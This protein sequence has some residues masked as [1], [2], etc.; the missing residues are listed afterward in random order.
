MSDSDNAESSEN[1]NV[2]ANV[3]ANANANAS[4]SVVFAAE[5]VGIHWNESNLETLSEWVQIG[6]LQI[7]TLDLAIKQYRSII[8]R[9]VLLGMIL[10]TASGSVSITQLSSSQQVFVLNVFFTAMSFTIA[11]LTGL[12]KIYQIQER[13]EEYIQLKQEWIAF[14]VN[15]TSEIQLPVSQRRDA[16]KIIK[17][18]KGKYLDL[19]KI[20]VDIDTRL[21]EK[22]L[23]NLYDDRKLQ[24]MEEHANYIKL[25]NDVNNGLFDDANT[26]ENMSHCG[27]KLVEQT[28]ITGCGCLGGGSGSGTNNKICFQSYFDAWFSNICKNKFDGRKTSLSNILLTI[29]MEE[30]KTER[31]KR[32]AQLMKRLNER[33]EQNEQKNLR[34]SIDM[35]IPSHLSLSPTELYSEAV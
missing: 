10:S 12:I 17:E 25:K 6:S 31:D 30:E 1:A 4:N 18:Y 28:V 11:I 13:L 34:N 20:D 21:K 22:A 7:E 35:K 5:M 26:A 19:L 16:L 8:R 23:E 32:T 3:N 15:I 29:V 27:D 33:K 2:N 9:N 14:C 24:Y